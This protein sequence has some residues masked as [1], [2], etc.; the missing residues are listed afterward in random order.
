[1]IIRHK[2]MIV[3]PKGM[4]LRGK[5]MFVWP[6]GTILRGKGM[7]L[8]LKGM[9]LR[10]KET[11]LES[12]RMEPCQQVGV[13][14]QRQAQTGGESWARGL[15]G[16]GTPLGFVN[17]Q[18]SGVVQGSQGSLASARYSWAARRKPVGLVY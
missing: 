11:F 12:K 8:W 14:D 6:K 1:M 10:D 5:G 16:D 15:A 3:W 4:I 17:G 2:G 7:V 13:R 9:F 18:G